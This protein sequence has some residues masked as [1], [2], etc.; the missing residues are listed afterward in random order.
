MAQAMSRAGEEEIAW[1]MGGPRPSW[2]LPDL[3]H[4]Y[5]CTCPNCHPYDPYAWDSD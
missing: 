5:E 4:A 1:Y 3:V 2:M